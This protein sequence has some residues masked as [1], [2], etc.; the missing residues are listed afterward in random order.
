[1][2]DLSDDLLCGPCGYNLRGVASDRCPECGAPFDRDHLV[3]NLIPWEQRRHIG[4]LRGFFATAWLATA[5]PRA[6]VAKADHPINGAAALVF[7]CIVVL[8]AAGAMIA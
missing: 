8:I 3:G 4:L 1:M 5:N 6:L 7:A 2:P